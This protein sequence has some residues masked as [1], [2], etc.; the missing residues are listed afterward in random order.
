MQIKL[1]KGAERKLVA[2]L[3]ETKTGVY[4]PALHP[5]SGNRTVYVSNSGMATASPH[6][7]QALATRIGHTPIYEG[8]SI[9]VEF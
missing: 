4:Y 5:V 3:G 6:T 1:T 7:L 2:V 8:D 9:T